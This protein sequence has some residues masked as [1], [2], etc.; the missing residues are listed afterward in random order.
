[1][2]D[3][4]LAVLASNALTARWVE[5]A[6]RDR[7]DFALSGAAV[8]PLLAALAAGAEGD[9]RDELEH[10]SGVSAD[11]ALAAA[12]EVIGGIDRAGGAHAAIGLWL[13]EGIPLRSDW[14]AALPEST[15]GL[16]HGPPEQDQATLDGWVRERTLGILDRLP[17]RIDERTLLL[18]VACLVI[19]ADWQ[20][21]FMSS[22]IP[23]EVPS[24]PWAGRLL[25][26]LS[27]RFY[28]L[29]RVTLVDSRVGELT[30]FDSLGADDIDVHLVIGPPD[31]SRAMSSA[32][33]L[34]RWPEHGRGE[35]WTICVR[36]TPLRE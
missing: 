20:T 29:D 32:R 5:V 3:A 30:I 10:A 21:R 24:G 18:L 12:V 35:A 25:Y 31:R 9:A 4:S 33:A 13:R 36:A 23:W 34:P 16:L 26:R 1:M 17:G 28:D 8:W 27:A 19:R 11:G 6:G 7:G 14:T 22:S 15:R 2:V